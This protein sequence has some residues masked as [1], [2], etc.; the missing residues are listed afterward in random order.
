MQQKSAYH[1][2]INVCAIGFERSVFNENY[3]ASNSPHRLI[4][5]NIVFLTHI[6][7]E[8]QQGNYD[9]VYFSVSSERQDSYADSVWA[10]KHNTSSCF[11]ALEELAQEIKC[12]TG[13]ENIEIE[14]YLLADSVKNLPSGT[15]FYFHRY[16]TE[17][18]CS[19][20]CLP[21]SQSGTAAFPLKK[22]ALIAQMHKI[23]AENPDSEIIF[24]VYDSNC[25]ILD[26]LY[27]QLHNVQ[28]GKSSYIPENLTI[29]L[30][31]DEVKAITFRGELKGTGLLS[32]DYSAHVNQFLVANKQEL[33]ALGNGMP[34]FINAQSRQN[35]LAGWPLSLYGRY[36]E[37]LVLM[38]NRTI[39]AEQENAY[40][41]IISALEALD[42]ILPKPHEDRASSHSNKIRRATVEM[43][44]GLVRLSK[45]APRE[46]KLA[47][48]S[49]YERK[50]E[51]ASASPVYVRAVGTVIL[52]AVGLFIGAAAGY[53]IGMLLGA[54]WAN[55]ID[56]ILNT[57]DLF[58]G[59]VTQGAIAFLTSTLIGGV[60]AGAIAGFLFFKP[61][62]LLI[63]ATTVARTARELVEEEASVTVKPVTTVN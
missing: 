25:H 7:Q 39:R 27:T 59:S 23:A 47:V 44:E 1:R 58:N 29:R 38:K 48:I 43:L 32:P 42:N 6:T 17:R 12:Q 49:A 9:Q 53:G 60:G 50:C 46:V 20:S 15:S 2:K 26:N 10:E 24:D 5:E 62:Q 8:I 36:H 31:Y 37:A 52:A 51:L 22:Q 30:H 61:D 57:V 28:P 13:A 55:P 11:S 21:F 19:E 4:E 16:S 41:S 40:P 3:S 56:A 18:N 45:H 14:P 35:L 33:S 54:D 34:N 63:Q